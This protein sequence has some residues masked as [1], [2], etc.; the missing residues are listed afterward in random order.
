MV[1]FFHLLSFNSIYF[2]VLI[3]NKAENILPKW[4]RFVK[5]VVD[6][7]DIPLNLSREL[8]QN[9]ALIGKLRYILT[10]KVLKFLQEKLAKEPTEYEKFH[11]DYGLFIK[12]GIVTTHDVLE[13]VKKSFITILLDIYVFSCKSYLTLWQNY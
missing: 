2:Q 13:K 6:S 9:S 10:T 7:E 4:L 1:S 3:K 5:G 11:Q 12:E 8:L